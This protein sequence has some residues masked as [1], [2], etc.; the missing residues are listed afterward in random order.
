MRLATS[1]KPQNVQA[2]SQSPKVK[3]PSFRGV[4]FCPQKPRL[5]P[6]DE[7]LSP[8]KLYLP[9]SPLKPD[10]KLKTVRTKKIPVRNKCRISQASVSTKQ[11]QLSPAGP[12]NVTR[13]GQLRI[14]PLSLATEMFSWQPFT[15]K[16]FR[17]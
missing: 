1:Q 14:P 13:R 17:D 9:P 4:P 16:P 7:W 10:H 11:L 12:Q 2:T 5:F 3:E 8:Q 15:N 6:Q